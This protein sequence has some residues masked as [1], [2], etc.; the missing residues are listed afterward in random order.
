[1]GN[2]GSKRAAQTI[3]KEYVIFM[4]F[5]G[6]KVFETEWENIHN[7]RKKDIMENVMGGIG[8]FGISGAMMSGGAGSTYEITWKDGREA[9]EVK[10]DRYQRVMRRVPI[11]REAVNV[12]SPLPI[13]AQRHGNQGS[14]C[15]PIPP[16]DHG[17]LYQQG[18]H[19]NKPE[20]PPPPY[21]QS[22]S[23]PSAPIKPQKEGETYN[24]F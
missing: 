18:K 16:P 13:H 14:Y 4:N 19:P 23:A 8:S 22:S 10:A 11:K 1:M 7:I 9:T 24:T 5:M 6:D 15:P 17:H 3:P 12:F 20:G 2:D 21:K